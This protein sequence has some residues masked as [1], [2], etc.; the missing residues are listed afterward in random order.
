M[1]TTTDS[2]PAKVISPARAL[3]LCS[4]PEHELYVASKP[5]ALKET[6]E[7]RL[8]ARVDR[9]RKLRDKYRDLAKRQQLEARGK[10]ASSGSRPASGHERTT[11][12][13]QL[14]EE[15]LA[16]LEK[17]LERIATKP[18]QG[19]KA[20]AAKVSSPRAKTPVRKSAVR[21]ERRSVAQG[22]RAA[23]R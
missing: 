14:F 8:R 20:G 10:K 2:P 15:V 3:A 12:K 17:R 19:G 13:A 9:A 11:Q 5:A 4:K 7:P 21:K 18:K 16:R 23:K 22:T 6:T 1:A